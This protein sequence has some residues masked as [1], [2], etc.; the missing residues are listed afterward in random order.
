VTTQKNHSWP[1]DVGA[2][3]KRVHLHQMVGGAHQWG[4]TSCL[5]GSAILVFSDA[6]KAQKFGYDKW[7]GFQRDGSFH[8]TGQGKFGPQTIESGSNRRLLRSSEDRKPIHVFLA[9][10]PLVTYVGQ[11]SLGIQPFRWEKAPDADGHE[12]SVVVFHLLPL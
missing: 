2:T 5:N 6:K 4:I 7:E 11:F 10:S 8:Y 9:H 3:L 12:R 1:V